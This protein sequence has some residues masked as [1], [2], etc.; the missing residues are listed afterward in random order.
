MRV[1]VRHSL[2]VRSGLAMDQGEGGM[3]PLS[4]M[5]ATKSTHAMPLESRRGPLFYN[6]ERSTP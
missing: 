5:E 1:R 6:N 4:D 2:H 3:S